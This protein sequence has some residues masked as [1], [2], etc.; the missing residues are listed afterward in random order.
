MGT[1]E[2]LDQKIFKTK[3]THEYNSM[4]TGFGADP[5]CLHCGRTMSHVMECGVWECKERKEYEE[6]LQDMV[7][8]RELENKKKLLDT[9]IGKSKTWGSHVWHLEENSDKIKIVKC[10]KCHHAR[11]YLKLMEKTSCNE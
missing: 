9:E 10:K 11:L 3:Y 6:M 4:C 1:R 7:K 2:K 5:Q 8:R